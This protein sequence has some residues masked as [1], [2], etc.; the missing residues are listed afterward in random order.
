MF[1]TV[2]GAGVASSYGIFIL[3]T[4]IALALIALAG[5]AVVHFSGRRFGSGGKNRRMK[6]IERLVL[7]PRRAIHLVEVDGETLL[8][9][10]SERSV[11]LLE[12][13]R[14]KP[15]VDASEAPEAPDAKE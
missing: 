4:L 11:A 15:E 3:E 7:E 14:P 8:I 9:G 1:L 10:T 5:W 13:R 12:K 2:T 6:L